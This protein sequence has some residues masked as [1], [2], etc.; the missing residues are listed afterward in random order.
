MNVKKAINMMV[1]NPA[2]D[3]PWKHA[4]FGLVNSVLPS[5]S[6]LDPLTAS[7]MELQDAVSTLDAATK[8]LLFDSTLTHGRDLGGQTPVVDNAEGAIDM[9]SRNALFIAFGATIC[10]CALVLTSKV[11]GGVGLESKEIVELL[12]LLLQALTATPEPAG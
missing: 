10:V 11:G 8:Q 1:R 9:K 2:V 4:L 6:Q 3:F 5:G 12:K 7:A